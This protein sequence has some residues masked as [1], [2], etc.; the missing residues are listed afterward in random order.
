MEDVGKNVMANMSGNS[1]SSECAAVMAGEG[2]TLK[3]VR[4]ILSCPLSSCKV[5]EDLFLREDGCAASSS[6]FYRD[7]LTSLASLY[8]TNS[9]ALLTLSVLLRRR[10]CSL[11]DQGWDS[12]AVN[13]AIVSVEAHT[14]LAHIV[15]DGPCAVAIKVN[16]LGACFIVRAP[17]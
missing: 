11:G 12:S 8:R 7:D 2:R 15:A 10:L 5:S 13:K 3:K 1:F 16:G 17:S 4:D 6:K 9:P 14:G